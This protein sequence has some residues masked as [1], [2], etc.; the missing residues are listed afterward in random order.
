LIVT[1]N[2]L[3]Q[4]PNISKTT[5]SLPNWHSCIQETRKWRM[6]AWNHSSE[7]YD[8]FKKLWAASKLSSSCTWKE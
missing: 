6:H 2:N 3:I 8:E 4:T 7:L 1:H 5:M